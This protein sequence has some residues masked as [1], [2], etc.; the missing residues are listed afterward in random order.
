MIWSTVLAQRQNL[1]CWRALS[2]SAR[3]LF[4]EFIGHTQRNLRWDRLAL[5]EI[6]RPVDL[7][8]LPHALTQGLDGALGGVGVAWSR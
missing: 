4:G 7:R 6:M 5:P 2:T 3:C 8:I 1:N